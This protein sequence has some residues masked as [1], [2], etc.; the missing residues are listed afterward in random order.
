MFTE[1][2]GHSLIDY[3]EY[4]SK[5]FGVKQPIGLKKVLNYLEDKAEIQKHDAL[6]DAI[7]LK[8]LVNKLND[9]A[10][11]DF[12]ENPFANKEKEAKEKQLKK[13]Y[14]EENTHYILFNFDTNKDLVFNSFS[15]MLNYR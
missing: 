8:D 3:A 14:I 4:V 15:Q 7:M 2:L 13:K 6:Q 12:K 9:M 1:L 11:E 10:P 5:F